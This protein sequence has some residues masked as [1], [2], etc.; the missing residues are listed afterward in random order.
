[1]LSQGIRCARDAADGA[2]P[3]AGLELGA[4]VGSGAPDETGAA[5]A[6]LGFGTWVGCGTRNVTPVHKNAPKMRKLEQIT[7]NAS[8]SFV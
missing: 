3:A 1:M 6:A 8:T 5:L 4:G 2:G 7:I